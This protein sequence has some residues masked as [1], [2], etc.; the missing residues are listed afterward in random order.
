MPIRTLAVTLSLFIL[1]GCSTHRQS[2]RPAPIAPAPYPV[3]VAQPPVP[4]YPAPPA[5][6]ISQSGGTTAPA[7][8]PPSPPPITSLPPAQ[9]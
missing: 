1:A 5:G 6:P 8:A 4:V 9:S 3:P 2:N 7:V